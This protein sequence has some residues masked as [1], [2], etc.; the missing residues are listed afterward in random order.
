V[1][2]VDEILYRKVSSADLK[3]IEGAKKPSSGG[4]QTYIDVSGV[5]VDNV[6]SFLRNGIEDPEKKKIDPSGIE[7]P[8]IL[9]NVQAIGTKEI[10]SLKFIPRTGTHGRVRNYY[11]AQQYQD[12][13][14]AWSESSSFPKLSDLFLP[15][16]TISSTHLKTIES[17]VKNLVIFIILTKKGRYYAG[18]INSSNLPPGWPNGVGL[19]KMLP[20]K[21]KARGSGSEQG[22]IK[23]S[24]VLGFTNDSLTPFNPFVSHDVVF[25][26][27][28]GE[29]IQETANISV[30][31]NKA[32][33]F[34]D[35]YHRPVERVETSAGKNKLKRDPRIGKAVIVDNSFKCL[36]DASHVTFLSRAT[37]HPYMEPHHLIPTKQFESFSNN[38]DCI[39]NIVP[40]CP[41]CHAMIHYGDKSEVE[42]VLD[43]LF[44]LCEP[45]LTK[46]GI[47][48]PLE[49]LKE[50][51]GII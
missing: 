51:Y 47:T 15:G 5:S 11:I 38:I 37:K 41:N 12:R 45:G 28:D 8:A 31:G 33:D 14:P 50:Y 43:R 27:D 35:S 25:D 42:P 10:K 22:L 24:I 21:W 18:F 7:Y 26:E 20:D 4:G 46:A 49:K 29:Y 9:I 40:L 16:T 36:V 19:E 32:A 1:E 2:I 3:N 44:M 13:H 17:R 30:I 6:V 23:P 48:I 39:Q 34:L